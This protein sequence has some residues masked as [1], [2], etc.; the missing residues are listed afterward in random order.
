MKKKSFF[1]RMLIPLSLSLSHFSTKTKT[2]QNHVETRQHF[3]FTPVPAAQRSR[4]GG[5]WRRAI[6]GAGQ[7][8]L[9]KI[10]GPQISKEQ[11]FD[12][13]MT[14]EQIRDFETN[15]IFVTIHQD[16]ASQ[17]QLEPVTPT[18]GVVRREM[19][20]LGVKYQ[21]VSAETSFVAVERWLDG[22]DCC[23]SSRLLAHNQSH[24]HAHNQSHVQ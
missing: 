22:Y 17:W 3:R 24:V 11:S 13:S 19:I 2:A 12:V 5:W 6:G 18:A 9:P 14:T 20:D 1:Y 7:V 23:R 8:N 4:V 21:I 10:V 15:I 16:A